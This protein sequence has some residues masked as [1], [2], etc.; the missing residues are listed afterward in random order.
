MISIK[1]LDSLQSVSKKVN[2]A[3]AS[4]INSKIKSKQ[5]SINSQAKNLALQWLM[6]QPEISSLSGGEL[7]GAFGLPVG[8]G[9][10]VV[11]AISSAFSNSVYSQVQQ[12]DSNLKSG[13]VFIYFQPS[14]FSNLLS[15]P[16]GHVLYGSGDLH[17]L[18]WL[19]ELGDQ[20]IV[21]GYSYNA[22]S[23]LGRSRLGYMEEGGV[24]RVPPQFSGTESDNFIT[25]ALIGSYQEQEIAKIFKKALS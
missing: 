1:L 18:Q 9:P 10:S 11:S 19:L 22:K 24:F 12:F 13:G 17:W 4:T 5:S 15:L 14:D 20:V 23:G 16:E 6:S 2:T 3:L 7:A 21:A 8:S 25:R